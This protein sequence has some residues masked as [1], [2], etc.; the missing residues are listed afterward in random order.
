MLNTF[1]ALLLILTCFLTFK[2]L[3]KKYSNILCN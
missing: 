2:V 1:Y 3:N